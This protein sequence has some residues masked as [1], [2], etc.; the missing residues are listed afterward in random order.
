[1]VFSFITFGFP[2]L[3]YLSIVTLPS[4]EDDKRLVHRFGRCLGWEIVGRVLV[5]VCVWFSLTFDVVCV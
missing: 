1:M 5:S 4:A 2:S 3:T